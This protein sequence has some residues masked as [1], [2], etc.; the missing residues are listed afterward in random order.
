[1][2]V[3]FRNRLH[4]DF[5][6]SGSAVVIAIGLGQWVA[7]GRVLVA[8]D[9]ADA[10]IVTFTASTDHATVTSYEVRVRSLLTNEI[11][12]SENIGKPTP[13]GSN[14]IQADMSTLFGT[15]DAGNYTVS[16]VAIDATGESE[17]VV[18]HA[19]SLPLS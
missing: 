18:S 12:A 16:V 10:G 1:M 11:V 15:L 9:S 7:Q 19:F 13:D 8:L 4:P 6:D 3:L 17:S 14:E 2:R 5:A